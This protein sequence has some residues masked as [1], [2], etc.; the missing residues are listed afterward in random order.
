LSVPLAY[1]NFNASLLNSSALSINQTV[2]GSN[3]GQG[4]LFATLLA[5]NAS[6]QPASASGAGMGG[7]D[8]PDAVGGKKKKGNQLAM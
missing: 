5:G 1:R 2:N 3:V 4:Y 6:A 8:Q 7:N